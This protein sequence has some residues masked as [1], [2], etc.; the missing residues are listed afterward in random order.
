METIHKY[1]NKYLAI[2]TLH[3]SDKIVIYECDNY[4][5]AADK[6]LPWKQNEV[7]EGEQALGFEK[8]GCFYTVRF[9]KDGNQEVRKWASKEDAVTNLKC[10]IV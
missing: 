5:D 6:I 2:K 9:L 10:E 7:L 4:L 3:M 1:G 8:N